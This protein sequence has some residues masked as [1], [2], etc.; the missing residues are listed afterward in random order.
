MDKSPEA[1]KRRWAIR[2]S[3]KEMEQ[4]ISDIKT[5]S[6]KMLNF[7]MGFPWDYYVEEYTDELEK[8]REDIESD[9]LKLKEMIVT[10]RNADAAY[11]EYLKGKR[12]G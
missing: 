3:H 12:N 11:T 2:N 4:T 8:R 9:L 10:F 5:K 1:V 7:C 6:E